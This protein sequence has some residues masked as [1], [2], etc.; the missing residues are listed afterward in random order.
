MKI[1]ILKNISLGMALT[2]ILG[3]LN[4]CS[5]SLVNPSNSNNT[6]SNIQASSTSIAIGKLSASATGSSSTAGDSI[7]L[8]NCFSPHSKK[9][10]ISF[11]SLP[12]SV[13]TYLSTNYSG[14]VFQKAFKVSDSLGNLVNYIVIIKF[15]N[16]Y[17]GLKFSSTGLFVSVLEQRGKA[18]MEGPGFHLGGPFQDRDGHHPDTL[19]L[20]ALPSTIKSFF[21]NNY[22]KDTLIHAAITRDSNY[23]LLSKNIYLYATLVS[24]SGKL[25]NRL[26]ITPHFY[27]HA[28]VLQANLPSNIL[29]YLTKT[30]PG[31]VFNMAYSES[32]SGTIM[33][34]DVFI[35]S[36]STKFLIDFDG[37]GNFIKSISLH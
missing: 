23:V 33:E 34:Y 15:N 11:S 26:Q 3:L 37:S 20:S 19:A 7:Y 6:G 27:S 22:P 31:Y 5:K 25:I 21:T 8:V 29:A 14:Y 24:S 16:N 28:T 17:L 10:S 4:S 35:T 30:Y 12:N 18:D 9:D 1:K 2:I 13:S 36:N 32:N